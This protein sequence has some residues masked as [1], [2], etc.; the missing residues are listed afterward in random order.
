MYVCMYVRKYV[1]MYVCINIYIYI[2]RESDRNNYQQYVEVYSRHLI[3][4]LKGTQDHELS[5]SLQ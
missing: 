2:E 5:W 4:S 3:Q 1:R